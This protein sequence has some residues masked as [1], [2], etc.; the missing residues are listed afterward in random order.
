M[1]APD[2]VSYEAAVVFSI[3]VYGTPRG[4]MICAAHKHYYSSTT[5]HV[6]SHLKVILPIMTSFADAD[7]NIRDDSLGGEPAED[8]EE[9]GASLSGVSP[10]ISNKPRKLHLPPRKQNQSIQAHTCLSPSSEHICNTCVTAGLSDGHLTPSFDSVGVVLFPSGEQ[11]LVDVEKLLCQTCSTVVP[12]EG[13]ED[14]LVVM[15]RSKSGAGST[16]IIIIMDGHW[17][18]EFSRKL[19]SS[20]DSFS[21]T[22]NNWEVGRRLLQSAAAGGE[23]EEQSVVHISKTKFF[24][25]LW[26]FLTYLT[27]PNVPDDALSCKNA[28][29]GPNP[30]V[31]VIDGVVIGLLTRNLGT[32][33]KYH[34]VP[35]QQLQFDRVSCSIYVDMYAL[36]CCPA[37]VLPYDRIITILIHTHSHSPT[38]T[39]TRPH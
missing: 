38:V 24:K 12:Y 25:F 10:P 17:L 37:A 29:C 19:Y 36:V 22:Y 2:G 31:I 1:G 35:E 18:A 13:K 4:K 15:E 28:T 34:T 30:N 7:D 9:V 32:T 23:A 20:R 5:S 39:Y 14:N 11:I 33:K 6:C 16:P 21:D 3:P 26:Q 27:V 8:H